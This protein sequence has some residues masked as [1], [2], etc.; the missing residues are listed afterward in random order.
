MFAKL[1]SYYKKH[2]ATADKDD[3]SSI[4]FLLPVVITL[5]MGISTI[6]IIS[7]Q[8][9]T[10]GSTLLNN[11]YFNNLAREAAQSGLALAKTCIL[12]GTKNWAELRPETN[13]NG[14]TSAG[15]Q[16]TVDSNS[17]FS[18]R[19]TVNAPQTL[20]PSTLV[21]TSTGLAEITTTN[22]ITITA[23]SITIRTIVK[24]S[25]TPTGDASKNV[26]QVSTNGSTTC[27]V[28]EGWVYCWGDNT[29][30]E[31]GV[32]NTSLSNNRSA[33]PLAV[34]TGALVNT[35]STK[36]YVTK[37]SV[38]TN[39]ICVIAKDNSTAAADVTRK[40]YCWGSNSSRQ[41][42]TTSASTRSSPYAVYAGTGSSL[43]NKVIKDISAGNEFTCALTTDG[44]VS[45]WGKNSSG[46][47]GNGSTGNQN[48]PSVFVNNTSGSALLN[49]TVAKL[50]QV[51]GAST[52]CAI[53]TNYK[54]Y[55]WG[56][57]TVGQ[58]GDANHAT[59]SNNTSESEQV[60][61]GG[62]RFTACNAYPNT[63]STVSIS[64][65]GALSVLRPTAVTSTTAFSSI[66]VFND[67]VTAISN[68]TNRAYWWG[69][70][71]ASTTTSRT[72]FV[73]YCRQNG[74]T[75]R[76]C[77]VLRTQTTTA[78]T[79]SA[80]TGPQYNSASS[81]LNKALTL[82]TG[83]VYNGLFC[84]QAGGL[85]YCDGHGKH[86]TYQ[87]LG[88]NNACTSS[89][90]SPSTPGAVFSSV[91]SWLSGK[92]ITDINS[93][94]NVTCVVADNAVGCWGANDKGQLG[95]GTTSSTGEKI[96]KPVDITTASGLHANGKLETG[97]N[98]PISF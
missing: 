43:Y 40:A 97:Y 30:K 58:I 18:S 52:M 57:N 65:T 80:P 62:Q 46:Q 89:C 70:G 6:S 92:T 90:P 67:S 45:C 84:A 76:Y 87:G 54:A 25:T 9:V 72:C 11:Q 98:A 75:T 82:A 15:R 96:P 44:L 60:I 21:I 22:G 55:C 68:G 85:L 41:L 32:G 20:N 37:V 33:V 26:T 86:T 93:N 17:V 61:G 2:T 77:R 78:Y 38:G 3:N 5:G 34:N 94:G 1:V 49:K 71:S 27:S 29:N 12:A 31:L 91:G 19:F 66:E 59:G 51:R 88:D 23:S 8:T 39:H 64:K 4:G 63:N 28:A 16:K 69:G 48:T 35:D 47:L 53:D 83:N 42:G 36:K 24:T 14:A 95:I 13:C 56:D 50:A 79:S 74:Q 7:L 81:N 10:S 73:Y